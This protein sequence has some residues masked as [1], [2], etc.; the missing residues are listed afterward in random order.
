[1]SAGL[2]LLAGRG[3]S[4]PLNVRDPSSPRFPPIARR[5]PRRCRP[6]P[7]YG[8][9]RCRSMRMWRPAAGW[10]SLVPI[11]R[12]APGRWSSGLATGGMC[13]WRAAAGRCSCRGSAAGGA[14]SRMPWSRPLSWRGGWMRRR[15]SAGSSRRWRAAGAGC[16]RQRRGWGCRTRLRAGGCGGSGLAPP[17]SGW[18]LRRWPSSWAGR[19][20]AR[21]LRLAGS[22]W[23]RSER[24][25]T[26]RAACRD[27]GRWAGGGSPAR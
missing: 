9:A 3:F 27:G 23:R 19:R 11:A 10:R 5:D 6:W 18:R 2:G 25:L 21:L 17:G 15:R 24:R 16:G 22:R 14:R 13:G 20:S 26:R 1:M 12:R 8:C 4:C 7:S